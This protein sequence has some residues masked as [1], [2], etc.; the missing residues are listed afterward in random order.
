MWR[1]RCV[2]QASLGPASLSGSPCFPDIE[3]CKTDCRQADGIS[4]TCLLICTY[5]IKLEALL[6]TS[7]DADVGFTSLIALR[8]SCCTGQRRH[9]APPGREGRGG[10]HPAGALGQTPRR[11]VS[12]QDQGV[13]GLH[14]AGWAQA[15]LKL[16]TLHAWGQLL[17]RVHHELFCCSSKTLMTAWRFHAC[18]QIYQGRTL[19]ASCETSFHAPAPASSCT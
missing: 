10:L 14:A 7:F 9:R 1:L 19:G 6:C 17:P 13:A 3:L 2:H 16:G 15:A 4:C 5:R 18:R 11:K 12:R 8:T